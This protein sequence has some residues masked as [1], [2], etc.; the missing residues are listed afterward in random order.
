MSSNKTLAARIA[1]ISKEIG[2]IA[3]SGKNTQQHYDFIEYA[4]VSGKMRDLLDKHGV[5]IIPSVTDYEKEIVESRNGAAGFHY[6]IRMHFT[7]INADDS[8]DRIEADWLGEASDYGDKAINKAET[9]GVKYFYMRL[10]NISE[11]GE[12]EADA[13]TP[14]MVVAKSEVRKNELDFD[15]I[16]E[17]LDMLDGIEDVVRYYNRLGK[18]KQSPAQKK[19]I[20][21]MFAA[22][23]KQLGIKD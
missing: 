19:Y 7:A 1:A 14:E 22:K 4:V 17:E 16:R 23:K 5:A 21:G 6:V 20:D 18:H 2:A 11:K 15:T 9:S 10:L 3:K 13:S 12:Q 8:A